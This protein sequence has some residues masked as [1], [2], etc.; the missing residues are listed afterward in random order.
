MK[1][2]RVAGAAALT[3]VLLVACVRYALSPEDEATERLAVKIT[4]KVM[5]LDAGEDERRQ[6]LLGEVERLLECQL[7]RYDAGEPDSG[8]VCRRPLGK[9]AGK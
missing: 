9:D 7:Q 5:R 4:R 2:A 3:A 8:V 6:V 1:P